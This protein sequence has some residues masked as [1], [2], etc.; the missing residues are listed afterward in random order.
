M[1]DNNIWRP[2][3]IAAVLFG[4][5]H[6]F[7]AE[8]PVERDIPRVQGELAGVFVEGQAVTAAVPADA[9]SQATRWQVL[10]DRAATVSSGDVP[11]SASRIDLGT[12]GIGWYRIEFLGQDGA[13]LAWTT[14]AVLARPVTPV[15]QDSP[16]CLDSAAAWFAP[17]DSGK[18]DRLARLAAL[19]GANWVRDRIR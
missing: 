6:A 9:A 3:L 2:W 8:L 19:A 17:D 10:D 18:Q 11:A 7:A 5:N 16:I 12:L 14:T 1:R 13:C 4:V 15:P